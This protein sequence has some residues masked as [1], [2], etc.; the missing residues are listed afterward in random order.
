MFQFFEKFKIAILAFIAAL[1]VA[2]AGCNKNE[3]PTPQPTETGKDTVYVFGS[4]QNANKLFCYSVT[5]F[6][7][8]NDGLTYFAD[9]L[10]MIYITVP[11]DS[12]AYLDIYK[13]GQTVATTMPILRE[14]SPLFM[15]MPANSS[16]RLR[17]TNGL[18][19]AFFKLYSCQQG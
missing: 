16:F 3:T 9:S 7:A 17:T 13:F 4:M 11:I 14:S 19:N 6:G 18:Q 10:S 1:M 2:L 8:S 12:I 15:V 5:E